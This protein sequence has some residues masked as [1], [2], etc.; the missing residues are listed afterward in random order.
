MKGAADRNP[1]KRSNGE[2]STNERVG[3]VSF[4]MKPGARWSVAYLLQP[5]GKAACDGVNVN[6]V[7][8]AQHN[9]LRSNAH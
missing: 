9:D 8:L 6:V 5:T 4:G 1:T 3:D 7:F 2:E